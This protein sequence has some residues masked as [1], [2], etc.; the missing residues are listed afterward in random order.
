MEKPSTLLTEYRSA[1]CLLILIL[2]NSM[3]VKQQHYMLAS[4]SARRNHL[5]ATHNTN[6]YQVST[7]HCNSRVVVFCSTAPHDQHKMGQ[8]VDFSGDNEN[9]GQDKQI[10]TIIFVVEFGCAMNLAA[11][12]ATQCTQPGIALSLNQGVGSRTVS[13]LKVEVLQISF[14]CFI[15]MIKFYW[16]DKTRLI[17]SLGPVNKIRRY[18]VT[19]SLIGWAQT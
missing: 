2:A 7:R 1:K 10:F 8:C 19:P 9:V 16:N 13:W 11:C 18:K 4:M 12:Q 17:L 15:G 6:Q 5:E 3:L 14:S